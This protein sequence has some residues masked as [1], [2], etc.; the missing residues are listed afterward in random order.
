MHRLSFTLTIVRQR[1]T[2]FYNNILTHTSCFNMIKPSIY[3]M[4]GERDALV[5]T[6]N[7][8]CQGDFS[9]FTF[10]L[11]ILSHS[12]QSFVAKNEGMGLV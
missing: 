8:K 1:L 10:I 2:F 6:V 4:R 5:K 7:V 3:H 11:D 12:H 9:N